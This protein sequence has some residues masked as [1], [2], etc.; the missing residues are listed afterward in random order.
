MLRL[1]STPHGDMLSFPTFWR[2]F[3]HSLVVALNVFPMISKC[4]QWGLDTAGLRDH[5][6]RL[7]HKVLESGKHPKK[8]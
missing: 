4:L 3:V 5:L 7:V 8:K 1:V 6:H 2:I